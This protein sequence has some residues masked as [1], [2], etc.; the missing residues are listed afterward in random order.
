MFQGLAKGSHIATVGPVQIAWHSGQP[1][2]PGTPAAKSPAL[3][4][5]PSAP[6]EEDS[7]MDGS[8]PVPVP[9]EDAPADDPHMHEETDAG[10]W[11]ADDDGFGMM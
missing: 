1:T 8:V 11:G 9:V 10:G 3:A 7:A 6:K 2:N 5:Q 4:S